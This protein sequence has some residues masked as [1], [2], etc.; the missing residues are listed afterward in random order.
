MA[1][2]TKT[3][4][5]KEKDRRKSAGNKN[6]LVTVLR[7]PSDKLRKIVAP[8]TIK[9]ETPVKES[10][11]PPAV[12]EETSN[13]SNPDN[14][15]NGQENGNDN[16]NG[17]GSGTPAAGTPSQSVMGPPTEASNKKRGTKRAKDSDPTA[18]IRSK[19][20]PKKKARL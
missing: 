16:G 1:P 17:S 11:A 9:A 4:P 8:E 18:K 14:V 2:T 10:P 13:A 7:V 12:P 6:S 20:G 19:P 3:S 15:E 5:S